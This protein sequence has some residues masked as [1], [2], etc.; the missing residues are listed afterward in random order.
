MYFPSFQPQIIQ[1]DKVEIE[2]REGNIQPDLI[3][4]VNSRKLYIEIAVTHFIDIKKKEKL[5]DKNIPTIEIDL[6]D[7]ERKIQYQQLEEILVSSIKRKKWIINNRNVQKLEHFLC[8]VREIESFIDYHKV[9]FKV[10]GKR[11]I[12]YNC[13]KK[14]TK[15]SESPVT[16]CYECKFHVHSY[17]SFD[18]DEPKDIED[19]DHCIECIGHQKNEYQNL[20]S[21][22]KNDY[23][24]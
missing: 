13:P 11:Q 16:D 4:Y 3:A 18:P 15:N 22:I 7:L 17:L 19:E 10:Y 9:T 23:K 12:I 21:K 5:K 14:N 1:I 2:K 8:A 6:S 24:K 20:I